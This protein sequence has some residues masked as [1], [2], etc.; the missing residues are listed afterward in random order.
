MTAALTTEQ[1]A[2]RA[3]E[4]P[5]E[6]ELTRRGIKLRGKIERSGPCPKCGGDDRFS[7]NIVK[8]VFNCRGCGLGGDVIHLVQHLDGVDFAT[9]CAT[10]A[11]EPA[12]NSKSNSKKLANGHDGDSA[13]EVT[14][15]RYTYKDENGAT[16]FVVGR[17]EYRN[18]DGSFVFKDGKRKKTFRQARPDPDNPGKWLRNVDGVRV[19]PY[20]LPELLEALGKNHFVVIVEGEAKADLLWTW[21]I[22][23]TCCACGA[24]KW[25][26]AHSEFLRGAEV[27]LLPDNDDPGRDHVNLV[28]TSLQGIAANIR[29][30]E[31]PDL[32]PKG[33]VVDFAAAGGTAEQLHDLIELE[34]KP[35]KV[36]K[37]KEASIPNRSNADDLKSDRPP[38]FSDEALALRFAE[39]HAD[40]LRY[41]APWSKWLEWTDKNWRFDDTMKAFDLARRTCR[42][43]ASECNQ[44]KAANA[45]ASAKTVAAVERLAK[46]DRRIAATVEQWDSDPW[47]LNT[48]EGVID[49]QTGNVRA[50]APS[51]HLIK[52][53][54]TAADKSC[55]IPNWRQ[56]LGR[57]TDNNIDLVAFLHRVAGY[58]LTG[59][60]REHALFFLYGTG[61]NGKTTFLNAIT[62]AIGDYCRIA[63]IETFTASNS[64]RHPTD[65]AGLRGARLVTAVETE[66]GRRWAESKIKALTGGDRI[67][68]RFMRQDFFEFT[69]QFKLLIAGNH[70]PGLRSVDEGIRRRLYL[71]PF[72][73]TIPAAERDPDLPEKLRAE[74]PGILHWMLDGCLQWQQQGLSPPSIVT[75]AT[76]A[77]LEAEDAMAAWIADCCELDPN[78]W[79]KRTALWTDWSGWAQKAGEYVGSQKRFIERLE[80]RSGITPKRQRTGDRGFL[81]L[82]L[83]SCSDVFGK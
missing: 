12:S 20:R 30:L 46:A 41:V 76:A 40:R 6:D 31:L 52:I 2:T 82:R 45:L 78:H 43:A 50:H 23:A 61:A 58:A 28:A 65:L 48:P 19:V 32:P 81:G 77:Y 49:L 51:D 69:P 68:A 79:E 9:A 22:P 57:V 47:L 15:A 17:F 53:T 18:A 26:L 74:R 80:V 38:T 11:N 34:A 75:A 42:V 60:T 1:W 62:G 63:P 8:Q 66:E 72:T 14:V 13:R 27:V 73:I 44:P 55:P 24:A 71:I 29:V 4:V 35:W 33:D 37:P 56:F 39:Q 16:L 67:S 36:Y 21:N 7:I 10:L 54:E 5:I 70:K 64:E 59:I 83:I 3:R 25:K